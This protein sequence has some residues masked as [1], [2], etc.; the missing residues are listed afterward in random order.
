MQ[1]RRWLSDNSAS[2]HASWV[3]EK[4]AYTSDN[5]IGNAQ[6]GRSLPTAIQD[7]EL[8]PSEHR[9]R[10]DGKKATRFYKPND[11]DLVTIE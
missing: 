5:A 2:Q 7:E 11:G 9:F 4:G 8:M 1:Q 6:L 3:H 10:D